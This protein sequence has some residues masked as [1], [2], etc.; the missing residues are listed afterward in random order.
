[1]FW[2]YSQIYSTKVAYGSGDKSTRG[3]DQTISIIKQFQIAFFKYEELW[4][5]AMH[6]RKTDFSQSAFAS[7]CSEKRNLARE[8]TISESI[9]TAKSMQFLIN[10]GKWKVSTHTNLNMP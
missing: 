10:K 4:W 3:A 2:A 5:I 1:M 8:S 9:F 6:W 7:A